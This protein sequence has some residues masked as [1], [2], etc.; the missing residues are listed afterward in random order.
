MSGRRG[1]VDPNFPPPGGKNDAPVIIYGYRPSLVVA[2]LGVILFAISTILH[3]WQLKKYKTRTFSALVLTGL[4]MEVV[5]YIFRLLSSRKNPYNVIYFVVQ[6]FFIVVAPVFFSAA[7]YTVLSTLITKLGRQFSYFSPRLILMTFIGVDVLCTALQMAGAALI[8]KAQTDR[9]DPTSANNILLAGLAIQVASF[10]VFLVLMAL[11]LLRAR[12]QIGEKGV[13]GRVSKGFLISF[14]VATLLIYLR[15]V[16][17]LAETAEGIYGALSSHEVYFGCLE[18]APVV[19]AV[20]LLTFWH[21][22]RCI[23]GM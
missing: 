21:P 1:Y 23:A 5:G 13:P 17:R 4:A 22:G 18:F 11:F 12:R 19:I 9:K 7:L 8:G 14:I 2:L 10:F 20:Y 3:S 6:Y 15:T 16:F